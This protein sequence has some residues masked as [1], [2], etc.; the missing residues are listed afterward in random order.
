MIKDFKGYGCNI[1][2]NGDK[3]FIKQLMLKEVCTISEIKNI[4]WTDPAMLTNGSIKLQTQKNLFQLNFTKKQIDN[5]KELY[6]YLCEQMSLSF[7]KD[8]NEISSKL[9]TKVSDVEYKGGHPLI[10]KEGKANIEIYNSKIAIE[11][12]MTR[13]E[14][15]FKNILNVNYE[16]QDQMEKR[17]TATR[18]LTLGV[19]ALAFKKKK[20]TTEKFLTVDFRDENDIE[21][22]VVFSGSNVSNAYSIIYS[23][24]S[25]Y[26]K[27][28]PIEKM[29][30]D[31][32]VAQ[33]DPYEE[34]KKIKE[35]LDL[36]IIT[37]EEF[38]K[39]K[40]ELLDL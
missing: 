4:N 19:F 9:I 32:V 5:F 20:K 15:D 12:F 18:L 24:L 25:D 21:I 3:L 29:T 16:T 22:T 11:C 13:H 26:K 10:T 14:I 27:T 35:L 31:N 23:A 28:H 37:N 8:I 1:S 38:D 34:L 36:G 2:V 17:I 6:N 30:S 33:N 39:K 40:R 7:G